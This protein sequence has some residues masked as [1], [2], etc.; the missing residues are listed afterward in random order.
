MRSHFL[1]YLSSTRHQSCWAKTPASPPQPPDPP[2]L[3][4]ETHILVYAHTGFHVHTHVHTRARTYA[5]LGFGSGEACGIHPR[6]P[7]WMSPRVRNWDRGEINTLE[8]KPSFWAGQAGGLA[9]PARLGP[10]CPSTSLVCLSLLLSPL[11]VHLVLEGL[12]EGRLTG[13]W[14]RGP[15]SL[16]FFQASLRRGLFFPDL[17]RSCP[18]PF[19]ASRKKTL[20]SF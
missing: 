10:R 9:H 3:R 13:G 14:T 11:S 2:T 5:P 6:A 17:D 18:T 1:R 8:E 15:Q 12:L 19:M 20:L 4:L 16:G 7:T